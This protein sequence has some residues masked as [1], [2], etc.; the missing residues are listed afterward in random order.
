MKPD[1]VLCCMFLLAY[2]AQVFLHKKEHHTRKEMEIHFLLATSMTFSND[3]FIGIYLPL[4][5]AVFSSSLK[6]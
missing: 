3:S 2:L 6:I 1:K 5:L 4:I